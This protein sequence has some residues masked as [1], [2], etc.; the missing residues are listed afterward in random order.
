MGVECLGPRI[1]L[2]LQI[3][4]ERALIDSYR[5][6]IS[7]ALP[8]PFDTECLAGFTFTAGA[9]SSSSDEIT[10]T[11]FG[12]FARDVREIGS[13]RR[14][15]DGTGFELEE[16][17]SFC[18]VLGLVAKDWLKGGRDEEGTL[19]G[20]GARVAEVTCAA[21]DGAKGRAAWGGLREPVVALPSGGDE[22]CWSPVNPESV[23]EVL[24]LGAANDPEV[25]IRLELICS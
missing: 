8:F 25:R 16:E 7:P 22:A 1:R 20:L 19:L 23:T 24:G 4:N 18:C 11:S 14:R 2:P 12:V 5:C 13:V 17:V 15:T 6:K 10:V 21:R 3:Q 9:M